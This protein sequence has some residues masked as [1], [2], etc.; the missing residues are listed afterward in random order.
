MVLSLSIF[1]VYRPYGS[2]W[3]FILQLQR[4]FEGFKWLLAK[5]GT[6]IVSMIRKF[7]QLK[8]IIIFKHLTYGLFGLL[9]TFPRF[10]TFDSV[11]ILFQ[12]ISKESQV[13]DHSWWATILNI[14]G[15]DFPIYNS[16]TGKWRETHLRFREPFE[17]VEDFLA[18]QFI[19]YFEVLVITTVFEVRRWLILFVD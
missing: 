17:I 13:V 12:G 7:E 16:C 3:L 5:V 15:N 10:V 14:R 19:K 11:F 2:R 1:G 9:W 18:L 6:F 8:L 4:L